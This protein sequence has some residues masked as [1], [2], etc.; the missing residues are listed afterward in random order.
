MNRIHRPKEVPEMKK[1]TTE[2]YRCECCLQA[3]DA[4]EIDIAVAV[5]VPENDECPYIGC[6]YEDGTYW[7]YGAKKSK[8]VTYEEME[9][10][11][12]SR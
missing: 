6:E 10:Y 3:G 4:P 7:I 8:Q 1:M 2:D 12:E 9:Q 11:L 5:Y